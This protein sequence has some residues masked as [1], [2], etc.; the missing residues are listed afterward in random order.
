MLLIANYTLM[1]FTEVEDKLCLL[2]G[3]STMHFNYF[4]N[5]LLLNL[6]SVVI[7]LHL[8]TVWVECINL[9]TRDEV[10]SLKRSRFLVLL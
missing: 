8:V 10:K 3:D 9:S 6:F 2:L 4:L 7:L 5:L 1:L